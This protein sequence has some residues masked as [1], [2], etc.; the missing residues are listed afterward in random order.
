MDKDINNILL[1]KFIHIYILFSIIIYCINLIIVNIFMYFI[2]D[3]TIYRTTYFTVNDT[4]FQTFPVISMLIA[5]IMFCLININIDQ[6]FDEDNNI[7]SY[8]L[9]IGTVFKARLKR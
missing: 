7:V 4:T 3:D 5:A 8:G 1:K 2:V 9:S 6:E